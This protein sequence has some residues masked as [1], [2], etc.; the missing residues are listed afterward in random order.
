MTTNQNTT[1]HSTEYL[2]AEQ[3]ACVLG[4]KLSRI[5]HLVF[6]KQIPHIKIG[7]SIRF[8]REQLEIWINSK[9]VTAGE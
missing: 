6:K 4:L 1:K 8:D 2:T 3:A 9:V 5:R 7:A